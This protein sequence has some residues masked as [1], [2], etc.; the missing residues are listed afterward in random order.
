MAFINRLKNK[1]D[2][3]ITGNNRE[4]SIPVKSIHYKGVE[5]FYS[6]GTSLIQRIEKS[7]AYEPE[8]VAAIVHNIK[9]ISEPIVIDLSL[10]H[11]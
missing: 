11:I 7:G 9:G 5:V 3:I 4:S 10:I 8:V 6:A 2:G 1:I